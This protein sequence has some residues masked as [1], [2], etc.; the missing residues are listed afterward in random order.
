MAREEEEG[1]RIQERDIIISSEPDFG[2]G[3]VIIKMS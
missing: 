3:Q 1:G 2:I